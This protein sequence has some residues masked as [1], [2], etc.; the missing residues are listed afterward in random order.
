LRGHGHEGSII[1]IGDEPHL[2]YERP[3]LSKEHLAS[4]EFFEPR[5]VATSAVLAENSVQIII[6]E[7][8][9]GLDTV[10]RTVKLEGGP[11]IGYDRL[12]LATGSAPRKLSVVDGLNNA[13][14][15]RTHECLHTRQGSYV[16][17]C[18]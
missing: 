17:D 4:E 1:L 5:V 16:R 18:R 9:V 15:L 10:A 13:F 7:K 12:L 6:G 2:P 3:P 8:A 11:S 14:Y